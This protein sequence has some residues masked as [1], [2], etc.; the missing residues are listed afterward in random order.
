MRIKTQQESQR[1]DTNASLSPPESNQIVK[2]CPDPLDLTMTTPAIPYERDKDKQSLLT[3]SQKKKSRVKYLS[4]EDFEK[5]IKPNKAPVS[6]LVERTVVTPSAPHRP[7][8]RVN[9]NET[10]TSSP[11]P[12]QVS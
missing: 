2:S 6:A 8:W 10:M 1:K 5:E 3:L 4:F 11:S 12:P 9:V 7:A